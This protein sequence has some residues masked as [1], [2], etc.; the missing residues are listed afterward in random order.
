MITS[1]VPTPPGVNGIFVPNL[2]KQKIAKSKSGDKFKLRA[3]QLTQN[4]KN[5]DS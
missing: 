4:I 1:V 5:I 2:P 3:S